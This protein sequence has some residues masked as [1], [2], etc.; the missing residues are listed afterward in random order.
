MAKLA[1]IGERHCMLS[2][3]SKSNKTDKHGNIYWN[4]KCDC[5]NIKEMTTSNFR[6]TQSCGCLTK[7]RMMKNSSKY[8]SVNQMKENANKCNQKTIIDG[9]NFGILN[10]SDFKNNTSGHKGVFWDRNAWRACVGY[11]KKIH[12]LY[13]SKNINDCIL[14]RE[15]AV[16]AINNGTF[17]N[18]FLKTE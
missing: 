3:D 11:K 4:V 8:Q 1:K 5:G 14:A 16:E 15:M 17:E 18:E 13:R 7:N 6:K 10:G 9:V 12:Y 2:I